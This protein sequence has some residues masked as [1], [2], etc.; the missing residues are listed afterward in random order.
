MIKG[1]IAFCVLVALITYS[2]MKIV[3]IWEF[4]K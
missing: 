1:F 3:E 4:W 2:G